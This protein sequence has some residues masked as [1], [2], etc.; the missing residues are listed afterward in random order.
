MALVMKSKE[1]KAIQEG[2]GQVCDT[3]NALAFRLL[4]S[5]DVV[6]SHDDDAAAWC[7]FYYSI[8]RIM[9]S[10]RV[11]LLALSTDVYSPTS[12]MLFILFLTINFVTD[13]RLA[14]TVSVHMTYMC[15]CCM[16]D[17]YVR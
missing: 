12:E 4:R 13:R 14:W 7:M 2:S 17:A 10:L 16:F 1:R 15:L 6:L 3:R 11:H 9:W 8:S 5:I